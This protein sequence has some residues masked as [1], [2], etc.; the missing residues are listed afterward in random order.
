MSSGNYIGFCV[1]S[2]FFL[3]LICSFLTF[4]APESIIFFTLIITSIF[5]LISISTS[6]LFFWFIDF[7]AKGFDKHQLEE[8]LQY[9]VEQFSKKEQELDK[10]L[11][12]IK[13]IEREDKEQS[14]R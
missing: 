9:Y 12:Y 3:G 8:S 13:K 14:H 1:V 10:T 2:G 4:D 7:Q 11:Q 5:Y 6:S